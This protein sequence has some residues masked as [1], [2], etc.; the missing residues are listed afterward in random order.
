MTRKILGRIPEGIDRFLARKGFAQLE[1]R[2]LVRTQILLSGILALAMVL[3]ARLSV[4][5][6]AFAAGALLA[7]MNFYSLAKVVQHLVNMPKGAVSALL[8]RFYFRL[9]LTGAALFGLIVWLDT[10]IWALLAGLSTILVTAL[11]WGATRF[12]GHNVK[13]A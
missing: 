13:E 1:V 8:V 9:I 10:P 3:A 2:R 12:H 11:Y 6:L 5:G 4:W 7:S